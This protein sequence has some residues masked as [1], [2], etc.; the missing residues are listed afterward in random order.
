[1]GYPLGA[2][3]HPDAPYNEKTKKISVCVSVTY[4]K[5]IELEVEGNYDDVTLNH[6][7]RETVYNTHKHMDDNGWVED[8][9]EVIEE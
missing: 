5:D 4:H 9:F 2:K 6:L 8:E 1:M 7:A 3:Y